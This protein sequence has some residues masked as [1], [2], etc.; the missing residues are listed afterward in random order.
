MM[1][2]ILGR[3]TIEGKTARGA[4]SPAKP[5][6]HMPLPLST[7]SAA[8]SSSAMASKLREQSTKFCTNA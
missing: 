4:S 7:T 3:P 8:T 1:P 6:L 2:G 5:A